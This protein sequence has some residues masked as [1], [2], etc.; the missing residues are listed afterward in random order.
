MNERRTPP[1]CEDGGT[2]RR[3]WRAPRLDLLEQPADGSV[4][5]TG[6]EG[7]GGVPGEAKSFL[8]DVERMGTMVN[9]GGVTVYTFTGPS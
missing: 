8:G 6:S 3:T 2:G 1:P 9:D 5:P 7:M 4:V